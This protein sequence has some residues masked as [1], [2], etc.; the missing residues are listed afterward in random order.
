ML[1]P[2]L[3]MKLALRRSNL[4]LKADFFDTQPHLMIVVLIPCSHSLTQ[5][6][7]NL[8]H[9]AVTYNNLIIILLLLLLL[10]CCAKVPLAVARVSPF[11]ATE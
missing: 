7:S 1:V 10:L 3:H 4:S 2:N 11:L 9:C 8:Y 5:T 6:W